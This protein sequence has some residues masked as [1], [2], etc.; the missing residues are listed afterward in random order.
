M[1]EELSELEVNEGSGNAFADFGLENAEV[2]KAAAFYSLRKSHFKKVNFDGEP[3]QRLDK[4]TC[5]I[6][7]KER[8]NSV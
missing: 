5:N 6:L 8:K 2:L 1:T 4:L 3:N 7:K